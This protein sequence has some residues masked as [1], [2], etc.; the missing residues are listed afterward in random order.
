LNCNGGLSN[1]T[2]TINI[3]K[4]FTGVHFL[5]DNDQAI[6]ADNDQWKK[7]LKIM[8]S[9]KDYWTV[10]QLLVRGDDRYPEYLL[11][12][13]SANGIAFFTFSSKTAPSYFRYSVITF[14]LSIVLVIGKLIRGVLVIGGN[15][16]F[17]FEMPRSE[18]LL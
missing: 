15:R 4:V 5:N 11:P 12:S 17:I 7:G 14:Y 13:S 18:P 16:I 6:P 2:S 8:Y 9:C 1:D 3:K 10:D